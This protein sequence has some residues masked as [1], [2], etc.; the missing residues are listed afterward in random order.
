MIKS[1]DTRRGL[2]P[3]IAPLTKQM[4]NYLNKIVAIVTEQT[5]INLD[6]H[7]I[8]DQQMHK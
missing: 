8:N 4:E 2:C 7:G 3:V 6:F 1:Y 5:E